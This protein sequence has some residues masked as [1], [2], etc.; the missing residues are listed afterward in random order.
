MQDVAQAVL[1]RETR[2]SHLLSEGFVLRAKARTGVPDDAG[3]GRRGDH[4]CRAAKALK[5]GVVTTTVEL[6]RR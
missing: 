1:R 6:Q 3:P 2:N 4:N 5:F